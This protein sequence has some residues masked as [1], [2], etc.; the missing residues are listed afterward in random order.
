MAVAG[1]VSELPEPAR[2]DG[3]GVAL[4]TEG[5]FTRTSSEA[6]T[7]SSGGNLAAAQGDAWLVRVGFEGSRP[8]ALGDGGSVVPSVEVGLRR[9]G[10]DAQSGVGAEFGGGL[11][12]VAGGLAPDLPA[13]GLVAHEASGLREWGASAAVGCDPDPSPRGLTAALRQTWGAA[14]SG[15]AD[16]PFGRPTMAGLDE[17]D[18][19]ALEAQ[20]GLE[21]EPGYGFAVFGGRGVAPPL[22]GRSRAGDSR[23]LR[24]GQ[25]LTPGASEWRVESGFAGE[26]RRFRAGDGCRL[27]SFLA[28]S[29][30]ASGREPANGDGPGRGVALRLNARR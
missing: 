19:G 21:A 8:F 12:V 26:S 27:E 1:A 17:G 2:Q 15:G 9:D 14:S 23:T 29:V 18:G 24:L 25:R 20:S 28:L 10:G 5:R 11:A 6:A 4:K 22:A 30:E 3:A 13:R 16:A 7:G